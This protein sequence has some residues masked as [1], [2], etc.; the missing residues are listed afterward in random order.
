MAMLQYS[1]PCISDHEM[2]IQQ[3]IASD[4]Q[5]KDRRSP[6]YQ[7]SL[8]PRE[9]AGGRQRTFSVRKPDKCF[10]QMV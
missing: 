6:L 2:Y 10:Y 5:D 4:L 8:S 7:T 3:V 9:A 1:L